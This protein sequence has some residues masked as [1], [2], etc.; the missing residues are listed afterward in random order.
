VL[1]V[2][3]GVIMIMLLVINLIVLKPITCLKDHILN[4]GRTSDLLSRLALQR[5]DEI[6]TLANEFDGM[7]VQLSDARKK[8]LEKSYYSG[9]AEMASGILHNARNILTPMVSKI[10]SLAE[11]MESVPLGNIQKALAELNDQ[12]L[13]PE[14]EK[15][16]NRYLRL[17]SSQM[18]DLIQNAGGGLRA[19]MHHVA[20]I[21]KILAEQDRFSYSERAVEKLYLTDIIQDAS[22]LMPQEYQERISIDIDTSLSEM[23]A[24]YAER[25]LLV[26][27]FNNLLN[28]AAESILMSGVPEGLISLDGEVKK[29]DSEQAI[30]ISIKDNGE[31]ID[32]DDIDRIFNR[33]FSSKG[34][35]HSGIGLHW[36]SNILISMGG[37]IYAESAGKG[38]GAC[39]NFEIPIQQDGNNR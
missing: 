35:G 4:V 15:A 6:G 9:I 26:Q 19:I 25:I 21:E 29:H 34:A 5:G 3:F 11:K 36:C 39:F 16:L 37:K 24:V 23:P 7:L 30:H 28:N 33:G 13:H 10:I 22:A 2:G 32:I 17:G 20:Q 18:A 12:D 27:V 1:A 14:R 8:L 31:G 38:K